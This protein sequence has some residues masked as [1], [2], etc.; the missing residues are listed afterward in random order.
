MLLLILA[1]WGR[2]PDRIQ[3]DF[4]IN[5]LRKIIHATEAMDNPQFCGVAEYTLSNTW[6]HYP[7]DI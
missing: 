7:V 2:K 6:R 3:W 4:Y 1:Y 5:R